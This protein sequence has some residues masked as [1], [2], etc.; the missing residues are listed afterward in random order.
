MYCTQQVSKINPEKKETAIVEYK[1]QCIISY[2]PKDA[3]I[4]STLHKISNY[5]SIPSKQEEKPIELIFD[6]Y[7]KIGLHKEMAG[8]FFKQLQN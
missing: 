1:H 7:I 8:K 6:R 5:L 3:V 2:F 4:K